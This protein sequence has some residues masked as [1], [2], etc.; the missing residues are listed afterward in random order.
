M[1]TVQASPSYQQMRIA[2]VKWVDLDEQQWH[3]LASKFQ[4]KLVQ[5]N[6]YLAL[7]G[8]KIHEL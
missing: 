1:K 2:L 6:E 5:K 7:P 4:V 8:T 3:L